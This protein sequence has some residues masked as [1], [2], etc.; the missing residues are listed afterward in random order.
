MR[1]T[2]VET[3]IEVEGKVLLKGFAKRTLSRRLCRFR[4]WCKLRQAYAQ[5]A[6]KKEKRG[7]H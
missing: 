5:Q 2:E 1:E 6:D 3:A 7:I 4:L